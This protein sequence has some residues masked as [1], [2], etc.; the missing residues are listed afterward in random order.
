MTKR[1]IVKQHIILIEIRA[2]DFKV[3]FVLSNYLFAS[4]R[5]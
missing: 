2:K 4:I 1:A 3:G 5:D